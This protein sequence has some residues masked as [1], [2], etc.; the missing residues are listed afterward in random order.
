MKYLL[1]SGEGKCEMYLTS[2]DPIPRLPKYVLSLRCL[3]VQ[4]LKC[5]SIP[6]QVGK[7]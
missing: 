3:M 6:M 7:I 2:Y 1:A 4:I 5:Y